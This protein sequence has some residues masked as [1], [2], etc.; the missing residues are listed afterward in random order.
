MAEL[1]AGS[2]PA[3]LKG[4]SGADVFYGS[5]ADVIFVGN[6][7]QDLFYGGSRNS[8]VDFRWANAPISINLSFDGW[9]NSGGAGHN[10]FV[11]ID[12]MYGTRFPDKVLG[13]NSNDMLSGE[14]G[15]DYL[16]G[17]W[18]WDDIFGG[19][20]NDTLE[21]G[22][23]NDT[24]AGGNGNDLVRGEIGDDVLKG[25]N[26]SDRLEGGP[27]ND[28]LEG[29]Y[30]DDILTGGPGYDKLFGGPGWDVARYDTSSRA[31]TIDLLDTAGYWN[32][33]DAA[34][35]GFNGIESFELSVWDDFFFADRHA[36]DVHGGAGND[37]IVGRGGKDRLYGDSGDDRVDGG[38]END[39]LFGGDGR[40]TLIGGTGI[41]VQY[42]G[43]GADRFI[44]QSEHE[45]VRPHPDTIGDFS[46]SEGD[47][48]DLSKIDAVRGGADNGFTFIGTNAFTGVAGQLAVRAGAN[49]IW[50]VLGD[51]N[52]DKVADFFL[53]VVTPLQPSAAD[54]VL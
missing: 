36:A 54:F 42:G 5:T 6:G 35:D 27:D 53:A 37:Q 48:I 33:G 52:G 12:G 26:G 30:G 7:G 9:Q 4:T 28:L 31:V 38:P 8:W 11:R 44:F 25:D 23:G 50:E 16:W 41:D 14:G 24:I 2:K 1:R 45:S 15:D 20:G 19:E 13:S 51:V 43:K 22:T 3:T 10:R 47:K 17:G 39:I 18:G 34:G 29:G 49:G 32:K 40:D 21:G 46:R